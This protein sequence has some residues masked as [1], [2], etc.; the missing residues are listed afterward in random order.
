M[1]RLAPPPS[2]RLIL[3]L[4]PIR[5]PEKHRINAVDIISWPSG[6][7]FEER[8]KQPNNQIND[9]MESRNGA[10]DEWGGD[11]MLVVARELEGDTEYTEYNGR[12][13]EMSTTIL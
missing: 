8:T 13:N 6:S 12:W 10:D 3:R 5:S 9:V 7:E 11:G 2:F 1:T 4:H